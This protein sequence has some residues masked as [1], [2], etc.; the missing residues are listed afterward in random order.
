MLSP[1]DKIACTVPSNRVQ[2]PIYPDTTLDVNRVVFIYFRVSLNIHGSLWKCLV[3]IM[4][5]IYSYSS[6]SG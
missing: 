4:F 1:I 6:D 2:H 3:C 5:E